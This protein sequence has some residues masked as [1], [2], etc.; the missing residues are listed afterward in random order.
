MGHILG[1]YS[2]TVTYPLRLRGYTGELWRCI[3]HILGWRK[4]LISHLLCSWP[5]LTCHGDPVQL[6]EEGRGERGGEGRG[7]EGR[8]GEGRGG[9]G[10]GGEGRGG[11]GRGGEGRGEE[12]RGGGGRALSNHTL[13]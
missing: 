4:L 3:V 11:E 10:R 7:G 6:I 8:G 13:S 9:E 5:G 12:G 2:N 1:I